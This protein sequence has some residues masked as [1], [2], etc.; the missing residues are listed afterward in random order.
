VCR[1]RSTQRHAAG[2]FKFRFCT[3]DEREV[4]ND[5]NVTT[6]VIATR[7]NLHASQVLAAFAA[8]KHVFCEKPL[9]LNE[10]ELVEIVRARGGSS[11]TRS[12]LLMVGFNRRFAP[13][14]VRMKQFLTIREPLA[15]HYRV[16]AGMG[17]GSKETGAWSAGCAVWSC[18]KAGGSSQQASR[19]RKITT[20]VCR[21]PRRDLRN[22]MPHPL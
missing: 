17:A 12:P 1:H 21:C 15:L 18:A 13:M 7:H 2:K 8:G 22:R 9:C 16:N 5:A 14:A 19:L 10:D 11:H 3:T 4:L 20:I 6:V